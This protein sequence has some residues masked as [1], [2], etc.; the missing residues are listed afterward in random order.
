MLILL[1]H[2]VVPVKQ[3]LRTLNAAY[4]CK[5]MYDTTHVCPY[6]S[7]FVSY[8]PLIFIF[9]AQF[10]IC[11][12]AYNVSLYKNNSA[13]T[14]IPFNTVFYDIWRCIRYC[15]D[16]VKPTF[17]WSANNKFYM[18]NGG[19]LSF[20][21]HIIYTMKY[22][23]V[24]LCSSITLFIPSQE[25]RAREVHFLSAVYVGVASIFKMYRELLMHWRQTNSLTQRICLQ[26]G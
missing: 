21:N 18:H 5:C 2:F 22:S 7:N 6:A 1:D 4:K 26:N 24:L 20:P 12:W 3:P 19:R 11:Y 8:L 13:S 15:L 17:L 9:A 25:N 10:L 16:M 14:T 23:V